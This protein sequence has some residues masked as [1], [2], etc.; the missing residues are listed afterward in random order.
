MDGSVGIVL[1]SSAAI[2]GLFMVF[3]GIQRIPWRDG[4]VIGIGMA[5]VLVVGGLASNGVLA[6]RD[7]G[8]LVIVGAIGGG[9]A[10]RGHERGK[11]RRDAAI[12]AIVGTR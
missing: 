9:I 6:A 3:A 10:V 12:S 1:V 4:F 2:A 7:V 8:T 11:A 5:I